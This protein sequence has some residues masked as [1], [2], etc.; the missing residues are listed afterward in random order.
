M[1]PTYKGRRA[2]AASIP[3]SNGQGYEVVGATTPYGKV[4]SVPIVP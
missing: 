3:N 4:L 2:F 1:T